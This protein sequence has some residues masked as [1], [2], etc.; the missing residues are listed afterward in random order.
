MNKYIWPYILLFLL[1]VFI[2][3][4]SQIML[5]WSATKQHT[6]RLREYV[7]P[8]V[9]TAYSIL[10]CSTFLTMLAYKHIPLSLGPMLEM[11]GYVYI[12]ILG[13]VVFKE[14]MTPKRWLA[15]ALICAGILVFS[16]GSY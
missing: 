8:W 1:S 2:S 11:T 6:S 13:I 4:I 9:L 16:I 7:N 12:T 14:K 10:F 5:K 3:S 15:L